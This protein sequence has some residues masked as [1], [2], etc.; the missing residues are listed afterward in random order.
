M[1]L[2]VTY[3]KRT[4]NKDYTALYA[5]IKSCCT[6]WWHYFENVW[7]IKTEYEPST[8]NNLIKKYLGEKDYCIVIKINT[9]PGDM[10]GWLPSKA[11]EWIKENRN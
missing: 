11:W 1:L 5:A 2:L 7:L 3:E 6:T 4:P 9:S 10:V 8:C